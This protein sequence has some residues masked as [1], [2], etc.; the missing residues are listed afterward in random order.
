MKRKIFF[1]ILLLTGI[2]LSGHTQTWDEWFKQKKTQRKYM[3]Q[4]IAKLQLYLSYVKKGYDIVHSG[5]E[6]ISDIKSGDFTLH[7]VFFDH[8]KQVSH[9]VKRCEKITDI[10]RMYT[11]MCNTYKTNFKRLKESGKLS[12]GEI[13]YLYQVFTNLLERASDDIELLTGILTDYQF[14]MSDKER[15]KRIDTLYD[16]MTS[17]YI[18]LSSFMNKTTVLLLQRQKELKDL[19]ILQNLYLP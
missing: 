17:N 5:M 14:E 7:S 6:L 10:I 18:S 13:D 11:G 8:L 15:L 9:T 16:S 19:E 4:Q 12:A 3:L 2:G 1:V